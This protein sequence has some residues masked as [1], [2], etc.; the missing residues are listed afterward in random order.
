MSL[1]CTVNIPRVIMSLCINIPT[2]RFNRYGAAGEKDGLT[3]LEWETLLLFLGRFRNP[4]CLGNKDYR[5]HSLVILK[6]LC[7]GGQDIQIWLCLCANLEASHSKQLNPRITPI[8]TEHHME[9]TLVAK[10]SG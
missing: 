7:T 2:R 8:S 5:Q 10:A 1:S 3:R 9:Q 6:D 4:I